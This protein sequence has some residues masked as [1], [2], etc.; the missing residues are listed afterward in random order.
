LAT[1]PSLAD[2]GFS[3]PFFRH[4]ALDLIPAEI[5]REQAPHDQKAAKATLEQHGCREPL[6]RHARLP[7]DQGLCS[8]VPFRANAKMITVYE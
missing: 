7:I 3:S 2:I 1:G 5:I 4:F 6:W 8:Q